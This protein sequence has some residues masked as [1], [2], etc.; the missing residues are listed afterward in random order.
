MKENLQHKILEKSQK[1]CRNLVYGYVR[2]HYIIY[3]HYLT[4]IITQLEVLS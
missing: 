4:N 2:Y 1:P 3:E